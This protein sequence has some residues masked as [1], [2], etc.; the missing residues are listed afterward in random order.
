[1]LCLSFFYSFERKSELYGYCTYCT[2]V[3]FYWWYKQLL[4]LWEETD[5]HCIPKYLINEYYNAKQKKLITKNSRLS[6]LQ[7]K[8]KEY[9]WKDFLKH[10]EIIV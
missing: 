5:K 8:K 1:M 10:I 6:V 7:K 2:R 3:Q 4:I 9:V